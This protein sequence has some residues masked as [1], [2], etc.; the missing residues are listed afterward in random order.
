MNKFLKGDTVWIL[1]EVA[2]DQDDNGWVKVRPFNSSGLPGDD[3]FADAKKAR[4]ETPRVDVGMWVSVGM[5]PYEVMAQT[6][7]YFWCRNQDGNF[8]QT[9]HISAITARRDGPRSRDPVFAAGEN[10]F[11]PAEP[12][13]VI[14]HKHTEIAS[15]SGYDVMQDNSKAEWWGNVDNW[16]D[17]DTMTRA[18][19]RAEFPQAHTIRA[20]DGFSMPTP[21]G[22]WTLL[23]GSAVWTYHYELPF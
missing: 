7:D 18:L 22:K 9:F 21:K 13:A 15:T 11:I 16:K 2:S 6:G 10:D 17:G 14:V 20:I 23:D 8:F 5:V 3:H 4:M 1:A 19:F 12:P